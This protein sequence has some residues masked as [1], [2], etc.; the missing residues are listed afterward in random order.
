MFISSKKII[1]TN[2]E[3]NVF[4]GY[5]NSNDKFCFIVVPPFRPESVPIYKLIMSDKNDTF[6]SLKDV[7]GSCDGEI[8]YALNNSITI[9]EYLKNYVQIQKPKQST[10]QL[11]IKLK[12]E[13]DE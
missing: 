2:Y 5:G 12:I 3:K 9:E 8:E 1:Q 6:I 13:S 4:L 10:K 11:N 7:K